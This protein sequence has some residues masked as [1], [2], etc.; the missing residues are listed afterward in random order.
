MPAIT[1][2][3]GGI[4]LTVLPAPSSSSNN[5]LEGASFA[6]SD[7]IPGSSDEGEQVGFT[8]TVAP[9]HSS[10]R[11]PVHVPPSNVLGTRRPA[12]HGSALFFWPMEDQDV[13]GCLTTTPVLGSSP[14]S[15]P[16]RSP[17]S[18]AALGGLDESISA[19]KGMGR[20]L[21]S[22]PGKAPLV[23][24]AS[25]ESRHPLASQLPIP[26]SPRDAACRKY[27]SNLPPP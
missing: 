23:K 6:D 14:W 20:L 8:G 25:A 21:A 7:V 24:C 12:L 2:N 22:V 26:H 3:D 11:I 16:S 4:P 10:A 5:C 15:S 19:H 1:Q 13:P 18:T 27:Q 17:S 9:P